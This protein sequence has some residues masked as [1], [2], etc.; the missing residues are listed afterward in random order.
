MSLFGIGARAL[1]INV[2]SSDS[3]YFD[4]NSLTPAHALGLDYL[5][6]EPPV[7]ANRNL[8]NILYEAKEEISINTENI[9]KAFDVGTNYPVWIGQLDDNGDLRTRTGY[10]AVAFIDPQDKVQFFTPSV[11]YNMFSI[12]ERN[13]GNLTFSPE[14]HKILVADS[15]NSFLQAQRINPIK[16][17]VFDRIRKK[18]YF[19][20]VNPNAVCRD[21]LNAVINKKLVRLPAAELSR[22]L[23]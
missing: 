13:G 15:S 17:V 4:H 7:L 11:L 19:V 1:S 9:A 14:S 8:F 23:S 10:Q 20:T 6:E 21:A 2:P 3:L 5:N 22:V 18:V 12:E 16:L